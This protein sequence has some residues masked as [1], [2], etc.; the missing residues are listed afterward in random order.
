MKQ[1]DSR[2]QHEEER[3]ADQER[4]AGPEPAVP[5]GEVHLGTAQRQQQRQCQ[6]EENCSS[7]LPYRIAQAL[8]DHVHRPTR[9]FL[10]CLLPPT[11]DQAVLRREMADSGNLPG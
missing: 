9:F 11:D 5:R 1:P 4:D 8:Q 7:D 2:T 3:E 6:E 10:S